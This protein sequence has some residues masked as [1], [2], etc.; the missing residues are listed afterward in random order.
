[1][2]KLF[3]SF[4]II[5]SIYLYI[6]YVHNQF[7][8]NKSDS[9]LI[10]FLSPMIFMNLW[11]VFDSYFQY[12]FKSYITSTARIFAFLILIFVRLLCL[13]LNV[14][15]LFISFLHILE[16]FFILFFLLVLFFRNTSVVNFKNIEFNL[17]LNE[18]KFYLFN[19]FKFLAIAFLLILQNKIIQIYIFNKFK[20]GVVGTFSL[21]TSFIEIILTITT[22]ISIL[23]LPKLISYYKKSFY[24]FYK[25][26]INKFIPYLIIIGFSITIFMLISGVF[27]INYYNNYPSIGI[28]YYVSILLIPLSF[29]SFG[30]NLYLIVVNK[31]NILLYTTL[32]SILLIYLLSNLFIQK[33]LQNGILYSYFIAQIIICIILPLLFIKSSFNLFL[34]SFRTLSNKSFY[35]NLLTRINLTNFNFIK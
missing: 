24:I 32:I 8:F 27:I 26:L 4:I 16:Q 6:H 33:Y 21:I 23:F 25:Y 2:L 13:Y 5:V 19:G 14:S 30:F 15:F 20:T 17:I 34:Y 22:F 1:M 3:L 11:T 28:F 18:F 10:L 12:Q 7:N 29:I 35:Y 31:P 9:N